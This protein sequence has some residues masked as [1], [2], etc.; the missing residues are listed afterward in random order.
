MFKSKSDSHKL[1]GLST[2]FLNDS[3]K[4]QKQFDYQLFTIW[5]HRIKRK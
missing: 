3:L 2:L 5:I 4:E 1:H